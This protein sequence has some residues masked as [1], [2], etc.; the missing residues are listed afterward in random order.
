MCDHSAR[1]CQRQNSCP[2][3]SGCAGKMAVALRR[4][5]AGT[6]FAT[7][8]RSTFS[9]CWSLLHLCWIGWNWFA[10]FAFG[11]WGHWL[12][13][14]CS[15]SQNWMHLLNESLEG[16]FSS[17]I[18]TGSDRSPS[19]WCLHWLWDYY[20]N[21]KASEQS[22]YSSDYPFQKFTN[23]AAFCQ[24]YHNHLLFPLATFGLASATQTCFQ[25]WYSDCSR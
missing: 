16:C 1:R 22:S 5:G 24:Y 18:W 9:S 21:A 3:C 11:P 12:S 20:S 23:V 14:P 19:S 10:S 6:W 15:F 25:S 7:G 2:S 4:T 17:W 13:S 8:T